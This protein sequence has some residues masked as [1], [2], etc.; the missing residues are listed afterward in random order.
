MFVALDAELVLPPLPPPPV[1]VLEIFASSTEVFGTS[2]RMSPSALAIIGSASANN[3]RT[4]LR[5]SSRRLAGFFISTLRVRTLGA[6]RPFAGDAPPVAT[7]I[8]V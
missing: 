8:P 2:S 3:V 6:R 4:E 7:T 1:L 5:R